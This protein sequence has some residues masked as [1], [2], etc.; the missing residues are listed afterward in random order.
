[1]LRSTLACLLAVSGCCTAQDTDEPRRFVDEHGEEWVEVLDRPPFGYLARPADGRAASRFVQTKP[2]PETEPWP[3]RVLILPDGNVEI[4]YEDLPYGQGALRWM[5]RAAVRIPIYSFDSEGNERPGVW[6]ET[7]ADHPCGREMTVVAKMILD[8]DRDENGFLSWDI[9]TDRVYM[10]HP[11]CGPGVSFMYPGSDESMIW[12]PG[13]TQPPVVMMGRG[14]NLINIFSAG[15]AVQ[16]PP[17]ALPAMARVEARFNKLLEAPSN[18]RG[19]QVRIDVE[20]TYD[21]IPDDTRPDLNI[22]GVLPFLNPK[23]LTIT[24]TGT[25]SLNEI[26][27]SLLLPV[28]LEETQANLDDARE[29]LLLD[30]NF[31][32]APDI[33]S[34]IGPGVFSPIPFTGSLERVGAGLGD[35]RVQNG[36]RGLYGPGTQ[37]VRVVI[38]D[39]EQWDFDPS[40]GVDPLTCDFEAALTHEMGHVLGFTSHADQTMANDYDSMTVLDLFRFD[41]NDLT[42]LGTGGRFVG[43][44]D[45][46][47]RAVLPSAD[48]ASALGRLSSDFFS[49]SRGD[50]MDP[51]DLTIFPP[52]DG[53]QA[54]HWRDDAFAG[55]AYIGVMDPSGFNGAP[56]NDPFLPHYLS[57]ADIRALD[58]IGWHIDSTDTPNQLLSLSDPAPGT[59]PIAGAADVGIPPVFTWTAP[60][61]NPGDLPGVTFVLYADALGPNNPAGATVLHRAD[62]LTGTSYTLPVGIVDPGTEYS[63]TTVT[64]NT[65]SY[66]R[67]GPYTFT[68]T[69]DCPADVNGDGM[70]SPADFNAW[71]LEFNTQG[72]GCD[73]NSDG[74]CTPADFSAWILNYNNGC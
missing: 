37:L 55:Q 8:R 18:S 26:R 38:D 3:E 24:S 12:F 62:S 64:Y 34:R 29:R 9:E 50:N 27:T 48:P 36:L 31:P 13:E 15:G 61:P 71:I 52:A 60:T 4:R 59:M 20:I 30:D 14:I 54:S 35:I 57:S 53:R 10:S 19:G 70:V 16:V 42:N 51:N 32:T 43:S 1:M 2:Y 40:D 69:T 63:W 67:S 68:T 21:D 39:S 6:H 44:D 49:M 11:P 66:N 45:R 72:P 65:W 28:F 74:L 22:D 41:R 7:S 56:G 33:W 73:Q 5:N 23:A 17:A 46:W 25:A 47:P 58:M